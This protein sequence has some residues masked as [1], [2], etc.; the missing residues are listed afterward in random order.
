MNMNE[1]EL[2]VCFRLKR[3]HP[4]LINVHPRS[5]PVDVQLRSDSDQS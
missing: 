4:D 5:F 3:T 1:R 2:R